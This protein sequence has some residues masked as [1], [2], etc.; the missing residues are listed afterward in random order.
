MLHTAAATFA[1]TARY[2]VVEEGDVTEADVD[3]PLALWATGVET[4][5]SIQ[6]LLDGDS[7][8]WRGSPSGSRA[9]RQSSAGRRAASRRS[10]PALRT[11]A[12]GSPPC[13][14]PTRR[15]QPRRDFLVRRELI[16]RPAPCG[17]HRKKDDPK[18]SGESA[19]AR[20]DRL[21]PSVRSSSSSCDGWENR[22]H[23]TAHTD[24]VG[25]F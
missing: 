9:M 19:T 7:G 17:S 6:R 3:Q 4:A 16:E 1:A 20:I 15:A 21:V 23:L 11:R 18:L 5:G 14:A 10:A 24:P 8:R 25:V 13:P 12:R 22:Q 2:H